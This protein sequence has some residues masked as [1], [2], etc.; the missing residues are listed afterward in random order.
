MSSQTKSLITES[1]KKFWRER[2]LGKHLEHKNAIE[3]WAKKMVDTN[4]NIDT[5]RK[6][7]GYGWSYIADM[8]MV[9]SQVLN[10]SK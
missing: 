9:A 4:A 5:T 1:E 6:E 2:L 8:Y 10:E 3:N 7:I